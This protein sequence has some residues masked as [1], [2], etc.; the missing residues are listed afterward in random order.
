M[1]RVVQELREL[2]SQVLPALVS[3][4]ALS[5]PLGMP[6]DVQV[7]YWSSPVFCW[8]LLAFVC[9]VSACFSHGGGT[10]SAMHYQRWSGGL[11]QACLAVGQ[12]LGRAGWCTNF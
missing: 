2:V 1:A 10:Q 5:A 9:F 12:A 3:G 6:L 8:P 11:V 7:G 4:A